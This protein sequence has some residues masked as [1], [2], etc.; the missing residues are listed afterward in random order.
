MCGRLFFLCAAGGEL[1]CMATISQSELVLSFEE[2]RS[3]VAEH[4][5]KIAGSRSLAEERV[6]LLSSLGRVLAQPVLADRDLP[7]F[8]RSARDGF[9]LNASDIA[10]ATEPQ[11]TP[12][13]VVAEIPAGTSAPLSPITSG[14]A[15]E[16]MTGAPVPPGADAVVM[17][18]YTRRKGDAVLVQRPAKAGENVV[19]RGAEAKSGQ[20]LLSAGTRIDHAAI[21]VAASVG[22]SALEV[23]RK[24]RVAILSTGDEL[25]DVASSPGPYQIRNSNSFSLAAQVLAAGG[26][27]AQLPVARDNLESLRPLVEEGLKADLL[28]LSGGVSMGKHDLVEQVLVEFSAEFFFT[29]ALIQPGRPAVFGRAKTSAEP[30]YFF[31]LPGNPVSTMV[32]F[33]LFARPILDALAGAQSS[34]LQFAQI[35][36]KSEIKTK[37][38]LTRFLPARLSGMHNQ[39]EVELVR[40]Q[41]SGDVVATA[42][43]NCYVVIP[44]NRDTIAAGELVSVLLR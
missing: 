4:A 17:V 26:E 43:A 15:A 36:L 9:A 8:S 29:G 35:K 20:Q 32:T 39:T 33:D 2:A 37:T 18:E 44:P 23:F 6:P 30:T 12:L 19:P 28:L 3:V 34:P 16:I 7:P 14:Q 1:I 21:A 27:P 42:A 10:S 40:W 25:I 22:E 38:G 24:P 41:G 5:G 31:G 11:P 13:L